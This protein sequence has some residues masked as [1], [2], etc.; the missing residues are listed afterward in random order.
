METLDHRAECLL[1][2][3]LRHMRDADSLLAASPDQSFHLAGFGPECARKAALGPKWL[4]RVFGHHLGAEAELILEFLEGIDPVAARYQLGQWSTSFPQ[5]A[6]WSPEVRYQR[7][8]TASREDSA[9]VVG[10]AYHVV[11]R[12]VASLWSDGRIRDAFV[13]EELVA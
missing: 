9:E 7:T 4:D 11:D 5:L 10:Q 3:A 1:S 12:L 13:R 8:G 6:R 2:A